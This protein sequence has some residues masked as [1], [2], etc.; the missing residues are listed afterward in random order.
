MMTLFCQDCHLRR[1]FQPPSG[2]SEHLFKACPRCGSV[3]IIQVTGKKALGYP[4]NTGAK[5]TQIVSAADALD[6]MLAEEKA[7]A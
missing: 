5:A 1:S 7:H 6:A 4:H 3:N 2:K